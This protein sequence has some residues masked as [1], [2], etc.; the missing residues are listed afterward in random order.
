MPE[1]LNHI[2]KQIDVNC[3]MG[4]GFHNE[5]DLMP[6]ISSANIAC[7]FHAGDSDTIK[8]T[9]ELAMRHH[10]AI[11][12]H[13]SYDDRENFGRQSQ[14]IS[15]LELA[16]LISDQLYLFEKVA[17]PMGAPIHHIKLHG[18]LYND[19]AKDAGLSKIFIQTVQAINPD[20]IIYGLSGSHTIQQA[21]NFGQPFANEVFAD[22]TY[23]NNGLLTPRYLDNAMIYDSQLAS[24]QVMKMIFEKKVAT[25][26]EEDIPIEADTVCIQ[27]EG[28]NAIP[29]ANHLYAILKQNNIAIKYP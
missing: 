17:I 22:H 8:R 19:C 5:A 9:I 24:E 12:V 7:G 23:Q 21:K 28:I 13:P 16:E 4:E 1:S 25:I 15:L 2:K 26:H 11:G 6:L 20:L 18:A 29:I 10:V 3:D 27:S 14:L